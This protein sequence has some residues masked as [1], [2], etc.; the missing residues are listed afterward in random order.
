VVAQRALGAVLSA[1]GFRALGLGARGRDPL[2]LGLQPGD[3]L[4]AGELVTVGFAGVVADDEPL[5]AFPVADHHFLDSQVVLD[6]L[7][8]ALARERGL[9]VR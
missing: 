4:F 9:R 3:R 8:A 5:G 1:V 7:V 6:G 2:Q